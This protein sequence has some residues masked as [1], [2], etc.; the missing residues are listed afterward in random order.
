M[1][2][3][4]SDKTGSHLLM[5]GIVSIFSV[6]LIVMAI[7]MSWETWIIPFIIIG[8]L[9]VWGIH[10]GKLSTE[11]RFEYLCTGIMIVEFF[12]YGSHAGYFLEIPVI[13]CILLFMLSLLDKKFLLYIVCGMYLLVLLY[14]IVVYRNIQIS[15][16]GVARFLLGFIAV[17]VALVL[18][19]A[20]IEKRKTEQEEMLEM[21]EQLDAAQQK[22]AAFLSNVSHELRTPINMVTG[23]SEVALGKILPKEIRDDMLSIQRAGRRLAGQINDIL[24]YTEIVGNTLVVTD[25][26]YMP[27]SIIN[28]VITM[29]TMQNNDH[30]LE[31]I[32]DMDTAIP[33]VLVGDA[34]KISR[35]IRILLQNAIK[36]TEE[37]GIYVSIGF[38]KE[39]YGINLDIYICDTGIGITSSQ[40]EQIYD[41][42]YQADTGRSRYAGGLGLGIPIARGLLYGMDGFIYYDSKEGQGTQVHISIPQKVADNTP[43]MI[44]HNAKQFCIVYYLKKESISRNEIWQFYNNMASHIA[45]GLGLEMYCAGHIEELEKLLRNHPVTHLFLAQKE[46]QEDMGY[47]EELAKRICVVLVV[48]KDYKLQTGSHLILLHKPFFALPIVNLLN[49]VTHG[50]DLKESMIEDKIFSCNGVRALVVDDEEMNLMVARGILNSY[51]IQIDTCQSGEAAIEQCI[52]TTYDLI[53]LDHMMP[54][55][56]GIETL[57]RIRAIKDG[58]YQQLPIIALTANAISGAKEMFKHEGFTEFVPKPIE[59]PVLERVLRKVLPEQKLQY[60]AVTK[61]E[62]QKTEKEKVQKAGNVLEIQEELTPLEFLKKSG[63]NVELGLSYC[64]EAEDF[65]KEMLQMYCSQCEERCE[66]LDNLYKAEDF[67]GYTVKVHALKSTSLTIGAEKVSGQAKALEQAGKEGNI[68]YIKEHHSELIKEY[69]VVCKDIIYSLGMA[70]GESTL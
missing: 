37:G 3:D 43:S 46:Y 19:S 26:N 36:F 31:M 60:S 25:E 54:G 27:S 4:K 41:D 14:Q 40:M 21:A 7:G 28:D 2:M 20:M 34:E 50:N 12:Y 51:N 38:R 61:E 35:V 1:G 11:T 22:N 17:F 53:F 68:L 49:G 33:S 45:Q 56:D 42:F 59:R 57:K 5:A 63:I 29:A 23:I 13:I 62:L 30:N 52:H 64:S 70:E 39:S 10:I 67:A 8:V 47:F 44:V 58:V 24:D 55:M 65:Y 16:S 6:L 9:A 32:F 15:F 69:Q 66:E 18:A 48:G